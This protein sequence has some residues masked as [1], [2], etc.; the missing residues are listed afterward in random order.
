MTCDARQLRTPV[1]KSAEPTRKTRAPLPNS[2]EQEHLH[3]TFRQLCIQREL[4]HEFHSG[5]ATG[6]PAPMLVTSRSMAAH[7]SLGTPC[8]FMKRRHAA[9][10]HHDFRPTGGD[11]RETV[12]GDTRGMLPCLCLNETGARSMSMQTVFP[13]LPLTRA[14]KVCRT[15]IKLVEQGPPLVA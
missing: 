6:W 4:R 1:R 11:E 8:L 9:L 3:R 10:L 5:A 13:A 7:Q 15:L 12:V 2:Q 14:N